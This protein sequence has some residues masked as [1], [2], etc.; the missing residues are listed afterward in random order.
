MVDGKH[1][2]MGREGNYAKINL[3]W[4]EIDIHI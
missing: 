2:L 4:S 3:T 1:T